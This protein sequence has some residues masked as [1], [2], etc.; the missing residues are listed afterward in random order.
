MWSAGDHWVEARA[1]LRFQAQ[2]LRSNPGI[3]EGVVIKR[4]VGLQVV[5]RGELTRVFVG[6]GL[7]QRDAEQRNPAH[8]VTHDLQKILNRCAFLYIVGEVE[9]GVVDCVDGDLG[10]AP[11]AAGQNKQRQPYNCNN[12]MTELLHRMNNRSRC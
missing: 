8:F 6:P 4:R 5:G 3:R 12:V 1:L 9:M 7:L 10:L 11:R 2:V